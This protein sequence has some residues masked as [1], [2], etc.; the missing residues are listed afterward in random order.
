MP[1]GDVGKSGQ[2]QGLRGFHLWR[3]FRSGSRR[4]WRGLAHASVMVPVVLQVPHRRHVRR[5]HAAQQVQHL[6]VL[7]LGHLVTVVIVTDKCCDQL[8]TVAA[9][10]CSCDHRCRIG[11]PPPGYH[12]RHLSSLLTID[13]LFCI[14]IT[15]HSCF[16]F[17]IITTA[18]PHRRKAEVRYNRYNRYPDQTSSS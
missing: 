13:L 18:A 3:P 11:A 7:C 2:V 9:H 12:H 15:L 4:G 10:K 16:H 14:H 1:C 17:S 8:A 5:H 6:C